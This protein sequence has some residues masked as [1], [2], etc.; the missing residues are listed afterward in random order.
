[1]PNFLMSSL[2]QDVQEGNYCIVKKCCMCR[3]LTQMAITLFIIVQINMYIWN[4]CN[5]YYSM[6]VYIY[7]TYSNIIVHL[8]VCNNIYQCNKVTTLGVKLNVK[9]VL[10]M[11]KIHISSRLQCSLTLNL[12]WH[13]VALMLRMYQ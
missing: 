2:V 8:I 5:Y 7:T 6:F 9:L 11:L 12:R 13:D 3:V 4:I 1:V 10:N